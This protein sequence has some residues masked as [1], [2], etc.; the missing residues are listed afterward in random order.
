M[1][2]QRITIT[3]TTLI[4][5][6]N[7]IDTDRITPARFLKEITFENMGD[8]LFYDVRFDASGAP[9]PHPLNTQEAKT[10]TILIV[11]KN[12]GC[13][14]SREHAAQAILRFGFEAII[15]ESFSEIF[16]G[17][18]RS[19]GIPTVTV[20]HETLQKIKAQLTPTQKISLNLQTKTLEIAGNK[21]P[22]QITE[23]NRQAFIS[24]TWNS[25]AMLKSNQEKIQK[26]NQTLPYKF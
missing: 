21:T 18:C 9:L 17:N 26:I 12:F 16:A 5:E 22:I 10:S 24:G 25:L 11:D 23:N 19:L 14:S 8:Y 4:I 15:G 1:N 20:S 2:A 7:D 13:G 6:G 3:G